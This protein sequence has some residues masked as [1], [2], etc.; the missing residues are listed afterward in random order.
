M[1]HNSC[2]ASMYSPYWNVGG[3]GYDDAGSNKAYADML[4]PQN[5]SYTGNRSTRTIRTCRE[6]LNYRIIVVCYV[7]RAF[8]KH[9]V[10][11][12]SLT[13]LRNASARSRSR[14]GNLYGINAPVSE[15]RPSGSGFSQECPKRLS[16]LR[17]RS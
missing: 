6:T 2:S 7:R 14:L 9:R 15:P 4:D 1:A 12:G 5:E 16:T 3:S 17:H 11:Y 13:V 8:V 10:R